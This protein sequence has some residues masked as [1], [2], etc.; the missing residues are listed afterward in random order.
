LAQY[1]NKLKLLKEWI[2]HKYSNRLIIIDEVHNIKEKDKE[3]IDFDLKLKRYDVIKLIAKFAKNNK[4]VLLS[5]TPMS[6][7]PTEIIGLLNILLINDGY[8]P[9]NQEKIFNKDET[10]IKFHIWVKIHIH[11]QIKYFQKV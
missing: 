7:T 3:E 6:H 8:K 4:F 11:F 2:E 5:G 1:D 9:L 10:L